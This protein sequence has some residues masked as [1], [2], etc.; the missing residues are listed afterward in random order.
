MRG[1]GSV[2]TSVN[3]KNS[4]QRRDEGI[5]QMAVVTSNSVAGAVQ[6]ET[7]SLN[8]LVLDEWI[9]YPPDLGKCVRTWNILRRLAR[10]HNISLLCYGDS[11][12]DAARIVRSA[13]IDVH[14]VAPFP[15]LAGWRLYLSLFR[16]LFSRYPYS[17]SKHYK[18]R[19]EARLRQVLGKGRFDLVHCELTPYARFLQAAD[20]FPNLIMA[21]NIE[22][23][24][25][26]RRAQ[27]S[28]TV[29]ERVFFTLQAQ[30]MRWFERAALR[31][32][33][34]VAVV[35]PLD[36]QQVR[37]WGAKA[38]SIVE[39]GVDLEEFRPAEEPPAASEILF[40]GP[41]DWYPNLD[42]VGYLVDRIMPLIVA[43][44]PEVK[45]RV[46]GRHP[47]L[48][49]QRKL[50]GRAW[51]EL[52]GEVADVRPYLARTAVVVVPLRI[53]GGS[54]IKIL[55]AL[56]MGKA[57]V[58]TTIGAEGLAVSEGVHLRLADPPEEFAQRTVELLESPE[59]RA[60]LGKWGRKLVEERYGWDQIAEA[61]ESAWLRTAGQGTRREPERCR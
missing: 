40:L 35:T 17:V 13:G 8:V 48:K 29:P 4:D 5:Q 39:N 51:V 2:A 6:P 30:K 38:V 20:G 50:A 60:R 34:G 1:D 32:V 57:V 25:W 42:A 47:P 14:T 7:R 9:P 37:Q 53:G 21:H 56:A 16:N 59:Q 41:L 36:A 11:E 10:R 46:V 24:I 28:G 3:P 55:E 45:L 33:D 18:Q 15:N 43:R 58:S 26:F 61:L 27:H 52:V 12:S 22:S 23:Q 49:L 44:L 54:R 31:R 19:F